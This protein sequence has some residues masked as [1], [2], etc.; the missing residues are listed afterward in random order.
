MRMTV[1]TASFFSALA[2]SLL[3]GQCEAS[4]VYLESGGQVVAEAE[5]FSRRTDVGSSG[6]VVRP[7]ENSAV[8]TANGG[9]M[10]ANARE[11]AYIQALPNEDDFFAPFLGP[12]VEYDL[13]IKTL[14][15]YQLYL[16]WDGDGF[17]QPEN[18]SLYA[19]VVQLKDGLDGIADH[20]Q[21]SGRNS[22]NDPLNLLPDGDFATTP[23]DGLGGF[24]ADNAAGTPRGPATWDITSPGLYTLRLGV[25]EDG[26]AVDAFS[27]QLANL[28]PP[29]GFGPAT[30][31][32]IPEPSGT[33]ICSLLAFVTS[34]CRR[35]RRLT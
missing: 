6:W 27:F 4:D 8:D 15:T 21:F 23:W 17:R 14:G 18:D 19:D 7:N 34:V 26:A 22:P 3:L 33:A 11:N 28:A 32:V 5:A 2:V 20:F 9:S 12:S 24:E 30:S 31:A 35:K 13:D 25:R 1:L 16:R 29:T 10:I